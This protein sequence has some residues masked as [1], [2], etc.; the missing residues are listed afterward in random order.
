MLIG[1]NGTTT[2]IRS[3]PGLN[4]GFYITP[5]I[6]NHSIICALLFATGNDYPERD[7][8][9]VTLEGTNAVDVGLLS[10]VVQQVL[11]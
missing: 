3:Q 1:L 10:I 9:E 11:I 5:N 2:Y 4:T 6:S 7:P 8:L